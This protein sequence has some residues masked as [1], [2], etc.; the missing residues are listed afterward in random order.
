VPVWDDTQANWGAQGGNSTGF[1]TIPYG[2]YTGATALTEVAIQPRYIIEIIPVNG[3]RVDT[4]GLGSQ[5]I[6]FRIT[7]RAVGQNSNTVVVLQ[8]VSSPF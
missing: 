4:A 1:P 2:T 8:S 6:I 5:V 7:A 3:N